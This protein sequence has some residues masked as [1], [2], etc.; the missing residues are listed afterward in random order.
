MSS[1]STVNTGLVLFAL[2]CSHECWARSFPQSSDFAF[3]CLG[4][5]VYLLSSSLGPSGRVRFDFTTCEN[6]VEVLP[7][8]PHARPLVE[9]AQSQGRNARLGAMLI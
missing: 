2:S 6:C 4:R 5:G 9:A 8:L 3:V 1:L 7:S